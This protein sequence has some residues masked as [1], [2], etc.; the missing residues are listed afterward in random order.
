VSWLERPGKWHR[1][2][3][4]AHGAL[5]ETLA[6]RVGLVAVALL[7]IGLGA[8][9]QWSRSKDDELFRDPVRVLLADGSACESSFKLAV[10]QEDGVE[11][12]YCTD[13]QGRIRTD[14]IYQLPTGGIGRSKFA[15]GK[16]TGVDEE[17][18]DGGEASGEKIGGRKMGVWRVVI[19]GVL[20]ASCEFDGGVRWG[21]CLEFGPAGNVVLDQQYVA[22][23]LQGKSTSYF[24]NAN[25]SESGA[26]DG[27]QKYGRWLTYSRFGELISIDDFPQ[28][29]SAKISGDAGFDEGSST[30]T[31]TK[32]GESVAWWRIRLAE[33]SKQSEKDPSLVP[34]YQL[35][36]RRAALQGIIQKETS[37]K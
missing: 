16:Y 30:L 26:F 21:Q 3:F 34:L 37:S 8:Y 9:R 29:A 19:N 4:G 1:R 27:G 25:V 11:K 28:V 15:K 2:I 36:V 35:T 20:S 13:D 7:L 33:L 31:V 12:T 5:C 17:V 23:K 22:G 18:F 32:G 6:M 24:E 14:K 10:V